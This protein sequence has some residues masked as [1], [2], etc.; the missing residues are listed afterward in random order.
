MGNLIT[1][2][3]LAERLSLRPGTIRRWTQAGIIP[4]LRLSGKVIR[5]DPV[6]VEQ[7]LKDRAV[8]ERDETDREREKQ[9]GGLLAVSTPKEQE[10]IEAGREAGRTL[11]RELEGLG[12]DE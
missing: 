10:Q 1:A 3:Q 9:I 4:C 7:T 11:R 5:F 8:Q 12:D 6:E 2:E